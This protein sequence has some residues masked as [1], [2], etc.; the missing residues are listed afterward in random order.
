MVMHNKAFMLLVT[1]FLAGCGHFKITPPAITGNLFCEIPKYELTVNTMPPALANDLML[2]IETNVEPLLFLSGGS[3]NGAFGAGF[4]D[5]W[6]KNNDGIL[7]KFSVVTGVST[8]AILSLSA[9]IGEPEAAVEGYSITSEDQVLDRF[10]KQKNGKLSP[11]DYL[12]TFKKGAMT[13]LGPFRQE[14]KR[15]LHDY[16]IIRKIAVGAGEHRKLYTAVVDFDTGNAVAF[17]MTQMAQKIVK[18]QDADKKSFFTD[19]FVEAVA[20][21][22][23]VPIAAL[24]VFIDNRMYIDGGVR[25]SVFSDEIAGVIKEYQGQMALD[26]EPVEPRDVFMIFNGDQAIAQKCG[27]LDPTLCT[28]TAPSGG[29]QGAHKDWDVLGLVGRTVSI[30]TDQVKQFSEYKIIRESGDAGY[31]LRSA[32]I[33]SDAGNHLFTNEGETK[34]CAAWKALDKVID[35]PLQFHPRYMR[36]LINY[37]RKIAND[38]AW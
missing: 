22:S 6:A 9:F 14:L 5:Q 31:F 23:S 21:S 18:T 24:P 35:N 17:D 3:Q 27:K 1:F 7:P 13:D 25:F 8:G 26:D 11:N 29:Q 16:D 36:C 10:V 12:K 2:A 34:T 19:C 4:I 15:I 32:K 28:P 33:E 37:G 30:L 20:A 38:K